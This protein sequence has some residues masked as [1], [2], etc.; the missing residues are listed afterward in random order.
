MSGEMEKKC[1]RVN[2]ND[3]KQSKFY[4]NNKFNTAFYDLT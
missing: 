1:R 3:K 2:I 4:Q